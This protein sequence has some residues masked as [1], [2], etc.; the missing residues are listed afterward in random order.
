MSLARFFGMVKQDCKNN[1]VYG[2]NSNRDYFSLLRRSS[3]IISSMM[4]S[5][6]VSA[7]NNGNFSIHWHGL[8]SS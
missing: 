6:S 8:T 3:A 5:V 7:N 2:F 4:N 1:S